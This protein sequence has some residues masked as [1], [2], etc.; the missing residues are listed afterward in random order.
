MRRL[1]EIEPRYH[2]LCW[3]F[4]VITSVVVAAADLTG[5]E[6]VCCPCDSGARSCCLIGMVV[7]VSC[8]FALAVLVAPSQPCV[9]V[10]RSS[11]VS[12]SASR[13]PPR[14]SQGAVYCW[15]R[16]DHNGVWKFALFYLPFAVMLPIGVYFGVRTLVFL[17][18][19]TQREAAA[20]AEIR[21]EEAA[22]AGV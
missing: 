11:A 1:R 12:L 17:H 18:K 16:V 4:M 14:P 2:A 20:A 21:R 19:Q 8:D 13:P 7:S 15:I 10:S 9:R 3:G 6:V 5:Q 22:A